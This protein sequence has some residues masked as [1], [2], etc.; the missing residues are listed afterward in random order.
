M[1][2]RWNSRLR[3]HHPALSYSIDP[4]LWAKNKWDLLLTTAWKLIEYTHTHTHTHTHI[5]IHDIFNSTHQ[6]LTCLHNLLCPS[7]IHRLGQD[8]PFYNTGS[9]LHLYWE[10]LAVCAYCVLEMSLKN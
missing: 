2:Q 3:S 8:C 1:A 6:Y 10:A 5:Y 7:G 4:S 9:I